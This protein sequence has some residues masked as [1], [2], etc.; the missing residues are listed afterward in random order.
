V[1]QDDAP[2]TRRS[3]KL[4]RAR[5]ARSCRAGLVSTL[6]APASPRMVETAP[7]SLAVMSHFEPMASELTTERLCLRPWRASDAGPYRLLWME[8]DRRSLRL[9]DAGGRPT[10]DDLRRQILEQPADD[11][12]LVLYAVERR[13]GPGFIGYCGLIVGGVGIEEPEI[14]FELAKSAHGHG[15]ATEAA[16]AVVEE[17]AAARRRRLWATVRAWNTPSFRVLDKLGFQASGRISPDPS[18]GDTVWMTKDL[19][20]TT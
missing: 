2:S 11:T 17:A 4:G 10:V 20:E 16:R 3:M 18:R 7:R 15:Y 19:T 1:R 5:D 12:G 13:G 6:P 9:I 8:R 14:A